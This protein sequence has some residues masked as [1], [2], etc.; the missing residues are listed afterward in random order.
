MKK[1]L[2]ALSLLFPLSLGAETFNYGFCPEDATEEEMTALGSGKNNDIEVM[3]RL[4]PDQMPQIKALKGSKV[5]GVRIKVRNDVEARARA[6]SRIGS[7]DAEPV[8]KNCYL[9]QGWNTVKFADPIEIGDEDIYVGCRLNETQGSGHHPILAYSAPAPSQTSYINIDLTGWQDSGEKGSVMVQAIIDAD[10]AILEAPAATATVFDYPQLVAPSAPFDAKLYIKNLSSKPISSLTVDYGHG[11][12]DLTAEIAPFGMAIIPTTLM[13]SAEE[14][15]DFP[16]VTSV[17]KINGTETTGYPSTTYL[18]VTKDVFTRIPLIEEWTGLT[19]VNCPFMAYYLDDAREISDIKTTYVCHHEGF[20]ADQLTQPVD[21]QLLFL[22]NGT[23][24]QKNPAVMYDRSYLPGNTEIILG[25]KEPAVDEYLESI[26]AA[27]KIPALANVEV[28]VDETN[29]TV[30]GKVSTGSKTSDGKVYLS[31]Y[32]IED[33][34]KPTAKNYPQLGI[35]ANVNPDAPADLVEKFRHNGVIRVNLTEVATGDKLQFDAEGNFEVKFPLPDFDK[36][37]KKE[38]MHVV[39]FIHRFDPNNL[40]D[41]Y[42]LNSGSSAPLA[43]SGLK[44]VA[45]QETESLTVVRGLNGQIVVLTPIRSAKAY[46]ISGREVNMRQSQPSGLYIVRA[47]LPDGR[48]ATAK[49]R[50]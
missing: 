15:T 31:A 47:T 18:Y 34:I 19:C 40:A 48:P 39:S 38:N 7:L 10:P 35:N 37:W 28:D 11:Q 25:A 27:S 23:Q 26:E 32:L 49:L 22:F 33:N 24:N 1:I 8:S 3:I 9:N 21:A 17:S 29:I 50:L 45:S 41:N 42:V 6:I 43:E 20:A 2:L 44:E 46:D 14:N 13:T 4:S 16:F 30:H 5:T 36:S 12:A